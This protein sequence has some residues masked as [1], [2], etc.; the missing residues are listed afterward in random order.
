MTESADAEAP[1]QRSLQSGWRRISTQPP[2]TVFSNIWAANS[3]M[4]TEMRRAWMK[5]NGFLPEPGLFDV[6]GFEADVGVDSDE[7]NG[8][9]RGRVGILR[10]VAA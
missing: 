10:R 1:S 9:A 6:V 2:G 4:A 8:G 3:W 5:V 7:L